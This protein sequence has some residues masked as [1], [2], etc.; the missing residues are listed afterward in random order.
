MARRDTVA[1]A[2]SA[3]AAAVAGAC[4]L[5]RARSEPLDTV[6]PA[7]RTLS[8]AE[9]RTADGNGERPAL[10]AA[11][12]TQATEVPRTRTYSVGGRTE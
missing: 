10:P 1:L 3:L 7:G 6:Q 8:R 4:A 2:I 9:F 11:E 12:K 5:S